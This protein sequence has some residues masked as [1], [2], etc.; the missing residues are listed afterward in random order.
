MANVAG[1][2]PARV[3]GTVGGEMSSKTACIHS[4]PDVMHAGRASRRTPSI[5]VDAGPMAA[6]RTR[7][8]G[9]LGGSEAMAL[10]R[11]LASTSILGEPRW[12]AA[13]NG[14][15]AAAAA[16]AIRQVRA[17][18]ADSVAS[19]LVMGNLLLLAERGDP[20]APTVIA[21]AL[22]ALARRGA[23]DR[24]LL[25]LAAR[26]ARPRRRPPRAVAEP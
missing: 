14:D 5:R 16:L 1:A 18:G 4:G 11:L 19:D 13:R 9:S 24:R 2:L 17:C 20:T 21:Y 10:A 12:P 22:R 26:W 6:W 3:S 7:A 8:P 25:R 23:G 15:A